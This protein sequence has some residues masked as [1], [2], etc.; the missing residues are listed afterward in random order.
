MRSLL[1]PVALGVACQD[2]SLSVRERV[3]VFLQDP[4]PAIDV[5]LVID[6]S[7]SMQGYQFLVGLRFNELLTWFERAG[8]DYQIAVTTTTINRPV[9]TYQGCTQADIDAVPD[10][11][12]LHLNTIITPQTESAEDVFYEIVNVGTCG[13]G[14]REAGLE[15]ARRALSPALLAG[16]NAGFVRDDAGLSV[17]FISDEQDF[18]TDPVH[19]YTADLFAVKQGRSRDLVN[20]SALV[21]TD[22]SDCIIPVAGSST[23]SRY[24]ALAEQTGGI[25]RNLCNTNFPE[26]MVEL[27]FSA[28]RLQD[29]FT[30]TGLPN[31]DTLE[32]SVDGEVVPC[33]RQTWRYTLS[34]GE[35][36]A[37]SAV[38][39]FERAT[40]PEAGA[41]ITAR[42]DLGDGAAEGFCPALDLF[43]DPEEAE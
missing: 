9:G 3:D 7:G 41:R 38:L 39:V 42:Y 24:V 32:V 8:V 5:L 34:T 30:L 1:L 22:A 15:A 16:P 26:S 36:G 35:D 17:I 4:P 25:T 12:H 13:D 14:N 19:L 40:L 33:T 27:S 18:S 37:P 21:I 20:A 11:G 10:A 43:G 28:S 23:G 31:V 29:T 2:Y 6:N